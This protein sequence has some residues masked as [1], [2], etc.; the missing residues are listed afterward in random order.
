MIMLD[1]SGSMDNPADRTSFLELPLDVNVDSNG[2]V[3]VLEYLRD[4]I[5]KFDADGNLLTRFGSTGS[6]AIN[7][8][9]HFNSRCMTDTY[10][11]LTLKTVEL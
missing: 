7:G 11:L 2:N 8:I 10:T 9:M 6:V 1:N 3:Y 5:A 4:R